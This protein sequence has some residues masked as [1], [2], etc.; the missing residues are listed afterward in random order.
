MPVN[1]EPPAHIPAT[2]VLT[3]L[4]TGRT[5]SGHEAYPMVAAS[6][7]MVLHSHPLP[8][9]LI[10]AHSGSCGPPGG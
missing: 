10:R 9:R 4:V 6:I 2:P 5:S 8:L 1:H 7:G 3:N